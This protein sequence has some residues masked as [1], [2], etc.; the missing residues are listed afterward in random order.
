MFSP[1]EGPGV[2]PID[3]P[4]TREVATMRASIRIIPSPSGP[5]SRHG[6]LAHRELED[7][8]DEQAER[9]VDGPES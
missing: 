5:K 2:I 3:V 1:R 8:E 4:S 6:S 9:Q 7:V